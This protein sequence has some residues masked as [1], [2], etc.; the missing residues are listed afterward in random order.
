MIK[1]V[2][3]NKYYNRSKNNE[4]HVL[5]NI[6]IEIEDKGLICLLGPSGCGKT[7]LLNVIGGLDDFDS[8][9]LYYH[10]RLVVSKE[11]DEIRINDV[12]FVFQN[13]V[14]F[15]DKTVYDNLRLVLNMYQLSESQID[16]RISYALKAVGMEK[17]KRRLASQL[18]GGKMQRIAIARGLVKSPNVIID[19]EPTGNLDEKNTTQIMNILKKLS[20]E[21]LVILVTH[22]RRLADFYGDRIIELLDGKITKDYV[23]SNRGSL[24][25]KD[26][27]NIYLQDLEQCILD[28]SLMYIRYFYVEEKPKIKLDVVCKN[29]TFFIQGI[30][31]NER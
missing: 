23:N 7:T 4:I 6:N 5:N 28:D 18:S 16:E 19:D 24:T 11:L 8:G 2:N 15:P 13:Y 29:D 10:D 12:G 30:P 20:N 27:T 1:L 26:E 31:D 17:Y 9:E 25:E 3:V 21:C 14:L 22:E